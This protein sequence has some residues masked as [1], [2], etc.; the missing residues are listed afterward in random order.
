MKLEAEAKDKFGNYFLRY[1]NGIVSA[2][3]KGL[4]SDSLAIKFSQDM[5]R[6]IKQ[7]PDAI[8]GYYSDQIE[9]IGYTPN[10]EKSL[11]ES[12]IYA[13]KAGCVVDAYRSGT[14]LSVDQISKIRRRAE[15][16]GN[17]SHRMF[18]NETLAKAYIQEKLQDLYQSTAD[19][20]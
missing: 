11:V 6:F 12:H 19:H 8:W 16:H 15:I 5:K 4:I 20:K 3:V 2:H 7:I 9:C 13:A 10:A 14:A 17:F 18:E 1:E